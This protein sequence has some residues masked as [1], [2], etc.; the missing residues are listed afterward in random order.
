MRRTTRLSSTFLL[1]LDREEFPN[2]DGIE[3]RELTRECRYINDDDDDVEK[4]IIAALNRQIEAF[5]YIIYLL[6][7]SLFIALSRFLSRFRHSR[8]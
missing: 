2:G 4:K 5:L 7:V 6:L 1:P 3:S 8:L